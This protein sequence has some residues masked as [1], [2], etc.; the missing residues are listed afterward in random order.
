ML[1]YS[2]DNK[3]DMTVI[4]SDTIQVASKEADD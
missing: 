3:I 1:G 4:N 2:R